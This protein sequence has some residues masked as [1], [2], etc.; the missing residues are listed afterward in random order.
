MEVQEGVA[1][2]RGVCTENL[3]TIR[4]H[5]SRHLVVRG[6]HVTADQEAEAPLEA[7]GRTAMEEAV[8]PSETEAVLL[9]VAVVQPEV[10]EGKAG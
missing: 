9:E 4:P 6:A 2:R 5:L 7:G 3:R 1:T 10:E 8:V